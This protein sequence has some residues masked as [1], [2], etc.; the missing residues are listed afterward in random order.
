MLVFSV[1][2]CWIAYV[3]IGKF[4]LKSDAIGVSFQEKMQDDDQREEK[5]WKVNSQKLYSKFRLRRNHSPSA[6]YLQKVN[7]Q[8][9]NKN[10][11]NVNTLWRSQKYLHI[12]RCY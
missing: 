7:T 9:G 3:L 11:H 12:A 2:F 8:K 6:I 4:A 1:N 5:M 10:V